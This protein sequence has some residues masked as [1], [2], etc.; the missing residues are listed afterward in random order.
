MGLAKLT[1]LIILVAAGFILCLYQHLPC[2]EREDL[3]AKLFVSAGAVDKLRELNSIAILLQGNESLITTIVED[4]LA[5]DLG[6][7]DFSIVRR[8]TIERWVSEELARRRN[9][10]DESAV[11]ATEVGRAVNADLVLTGTIISAVGKD[12]AFEVR[13]ASFQVIDVKTDSTLIAVLYDSHLRDLFPKLGNLV[14]DLL[15]CPK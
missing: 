11:T 15:T 7:A 10:R 6:N 12:K 2:E 13:I 14:V 3:L 1:A 5:I 9:A 4:I 8:D